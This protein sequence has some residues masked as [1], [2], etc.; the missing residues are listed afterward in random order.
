MNLYS[1]SLLFIEDPITYY[2]SIYSLVA[3]TI[4]AYETEALKFNQRD[5][6]L[7]VNINKFHAIACKLNT[8]SAYWKLP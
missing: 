7:D 3:I 4:K 6:W 8:E 1:V 2:D 5:N